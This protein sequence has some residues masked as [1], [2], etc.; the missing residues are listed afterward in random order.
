MPKVR[1]QD[2]EKYKEKPNYKKI[3]ERKKSEKDF[4]REKDKD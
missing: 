2:L 4:Y 3:K 1:I